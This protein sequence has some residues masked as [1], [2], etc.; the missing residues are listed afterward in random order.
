MTKSNKK[1]LIIWDFDGV[2]AD[3]EKL[4]V[5]VWRQLLKEEKGLV[6]SA[7]QELKWL[8]GIADKEK[9]NNIERFFAPVILD[10]S[11][12][13]KINEGEIYMGSHFMEPMPGV[14]EVL[15]DTSFNHCIATGATRTQQKWK[16]KNLGWLKKY[17][18]MKD[19]FTVDMVKHGKPDPD[20]FLFAAKSKG[21]D[22]KDCIVVEDSLHGMKA[23]GAAGIKCIA[24]VGA[25]G[26]NTPE[27][28]KKCSD[29]GV[30]A[31]CDTMPSLHETLKRLL[32][33]K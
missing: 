12:M 2:L 6:L 4:W 18:P 9:K 28:R 30:V 20:L 19:I 5:Q 26:N 17:I 1:P 29:M 14:E 22:V 15:A 27:Y 16:M 32:L 25:E 13:G 3:S 8:V 10:D 31:I 21:Y 11:F 33:S 7:E 23:A 24:F